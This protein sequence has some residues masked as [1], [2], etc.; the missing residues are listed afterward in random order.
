M[1]PDFEVPLPENYTFE[2]AEH[3][4][5]Y[6]YDTYLPKVLSLCKAIQ[7]MYDRH[8]TAKNYPEKDAEKLKR[9]IDNYFLPNTMRL[10]DHIENAY[11]VKS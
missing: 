9:F 7:I 8:H 11:N 4:R 10:Q 2:D 5:D 3:S 6:L 1:D